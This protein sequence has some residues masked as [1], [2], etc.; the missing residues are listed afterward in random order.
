MI[1]TKTEILGW[2]AIGFICIL[3]CIGAGILI[4]GIYTLLGAAIIF[5]LSLLNV[6]TFSWT[7]S[8]AVGIILFVY[9]MVT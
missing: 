4:F 9:N 1:E 7:Y 5:A 6:L 8:I 3:F 2:L